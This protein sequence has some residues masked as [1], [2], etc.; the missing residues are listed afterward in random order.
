MILR[1][2][3]P[4]FFLCL[5]NLRYACLGCESSDE[6]DIILFLEEFLEPEDATMGTTKVFLR[7]VA[8]SFFFEQTK[9]KPL[10]LKANTNYQPTKNSNLP[11]P[12]NDN[13]QVECLEAE[14]QAKLEDNVIILQSCVRRMWAAKHLE[15]KKIQFENART[16]QKYVPSDCILK[17]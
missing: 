7:S 13:N 5:P 3:T 15:R 10:M 1:R 4:S 16:L 14:R 6:A 8:V 2:G 9:T 17:I 11:T 12:C